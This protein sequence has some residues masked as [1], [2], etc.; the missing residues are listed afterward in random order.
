MAGIYIHIPFC[1]RKCS[2]C[3]FYSEPQQELI[4]PF[5]DALIAEMSL[6][7]DYLPDT[8]VDTVYLGGG[9]PSL[10]KKADFERLFDALNRH[11]HI[12]RD[13]EITIEANPDDLTCE[14]LGQLAS[15]P[16][17]RISMGVQSFNDRFLRLLNRRHSARQASLAI[18]HAQQAGFGNISIDLMYGLPGQTLDDWSRDLDTALHA[19]VQHLSAYGLSYEEGTPMHRLLTAGRLSAVGDD[20]MNAMYRLLLQRTG[21]NGLEAYEISNFARPGCRS[22]H[23]SAYWEQVPYIGLGPSAHSFDGPSRQWN[24]SSIA[25]YL[26]AIQ[27]GSVPAEKETLSADERYNDFVMLSLR[28]AKGIDTERLERLF[29]SERTEYCLKNIRPFIRTGHALMADGCIRLGVE[30]ILISNLI[31]SELMRV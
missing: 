13:A 2:Y 8:R 3:S 30:G 6:R 25:G 24:V 18:S 23:N 21:E 15:L 1:A 4:P 31:M 9:T 11:W 7:K 10:L 17:N 16:F 20:E 22:R 14:Y 19:G 5:I 29:G 27:S 28:T 26:Q 12:A